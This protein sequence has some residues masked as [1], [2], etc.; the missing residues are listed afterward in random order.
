M[1]VVVHEGPF[2]G[3]V[4]AD[5]DRQCVANAGFLDSLVELGHCLKSS[6]IAGSPHER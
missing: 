2:E 4:E 5:E 3:G 6:D 1:E